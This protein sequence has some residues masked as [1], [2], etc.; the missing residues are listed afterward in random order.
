ME[1]R[2]EV[3][4][5]EVV[6]DRD[7]HSDISVAFSPDGTRLVAGFQDGTVRLWDVATQ[8]ETARLEGH[9]D[10]VT[11]VSFSPDGALLASAGGW[12]DATVRLWDAATQTEVATLR[13]HTREVRSVAF[14]SP[15][16]ATLASGGGTA[17]SGCG[18]WLHTRRWPPS[19]NTGT[20]FVQ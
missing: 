3:A 14:S 17:R 5:W 12:N 19:R 8:T 15:D 13:G 6:R 18:T 4:T 16:G 10:R 1:T 11:S 2:G 7:Y 20:G 9:T